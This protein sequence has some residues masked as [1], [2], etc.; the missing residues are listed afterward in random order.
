MSEEYIDSKGCS[1][2]IIGNRAILTIKGTLSTERAETLKSPVLRAISGASEVVLR[3]ES[4]RDADMAIIQLLSSACQSALLMSKRV[5]L[6]GDGVDEFL[7]VAE[8][9]G[10]DRDALCSCREGSEL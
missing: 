3:A 5:Y 8:S 4:F 6:E 7:T 10:F 1:L 2:E 9:A